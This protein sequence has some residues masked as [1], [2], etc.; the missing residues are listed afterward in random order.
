MGKHILLI[1]A[2]LLCVPPALAKPPVVLVL[3]DSL[4]AGYGIDVQAGWV[5]LLAQRLTQQGYP[6]RVINASISGDT[7]GGG[8]ARLPRL[9]AMHNPDLVIIEL[10]ANDG[11]R[12]LSLTVMQNN[13]AAMI[14]A[15]RTHG[16]RVVLVGMHLPT[17]YGSAYTEKFHAT[18]VDLARQ[19]KIPLVPFLLDKVALD[20]QLMQ[21]DGLHPRATAQAQLLDNVWPLLKPLLAARTSRAQSLKFLNM[22]TYSAL[23]L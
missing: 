13:L 1:I 8:R 20:A 11:L 14:K 3:G 15:T 5:A 21:A 18:Y 23:G 19:L 6:H 7:S 12:G 16:A 22:A 10:G 17:N 4:S 9:L 2:F